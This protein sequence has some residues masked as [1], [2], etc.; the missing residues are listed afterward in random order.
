LARQNALLF[1]VSAG[2]VSDRALAR[3]DLTKLRLAAEIQKNIIPRAIGY[4]TFRP[5][6]KYITGTQD[7]AE[8]QLIPFVFNTSTKAL[9]ELTPSLMRVLVDDVPVT[10]G[11]VS[12]AITNGTFTS[13]VASW[14]D[15]DDVGGT[16]AWVTGGYLGLTGNG[17][18]F[19]VR[20][21]EVTVVAGDQ[22]DEH[23]LRIIIERGPVVFRVGSTEGGDEY[24]NETTLQTGTHSLTFTPT[25]NFWIQFQSSL[26]RQV[27]VDSV[28]VESSGVMTLPTPWGADEI[29]DIHYHQSGDVVFCAQD[30]T[31]Q[32]RIERRSAHSWSVV[33]YLSN[34]G[35]FRVAATSGIK[36]TPNA[37]TGNITLTASKPFFRSGHV[38]ALFRLAHNKQVATHTVTGAD[39]YTD[40]IR[41][42]GADPDNRFNIVITGLTGTGSTV[43]YQRSIDVKDD[44]IDNLPAETANASTDVAS[45]RYDNQVFYVRAGVKSG[46]YST[47]TPAIT[48]TYNGGTKNGIVRITAVASSTS[49]SAEVISDL[50][51][52]SATEVWDEGS[53]SDVRGW[54][55][56]VTLHDGRLWW[57][58]KDFVYGSVSDE[59]SN[60]DDTTVG[61]SG[62]I[63]RSLALGPIEGVI[64]LLSMQRLLGGTAS[65]VVSMRASSLDEPMTPTNFGVREISNRGT[66]HLQAVKVDT[67]GIYVQ[68]NTTRVREI[69]FGIENNDYT[70]DDLTKFKP[71]MCDAGIVSIAVQN[72]PDT[73]IWCV[74]DDGSVAMCCYDRTEEMVSWIDIDFGD[75]L[76]VAVTV[77]PGTEEDDVYLAI[78]RTINGSD[79]CY[80]EKMALESECVGGSLNKNMDSHYVYSGASTSTI[81]GLDHLEGE[82]VVV[83]GNS[84]A[85]HDQ[86]DMK[87]VTSGSITIGES[88][89][90]AVVGLPYDGRFKP[91]KLAYGAQ[92]GTAIGQKK[93]ISHLLILLADTVHKGITYGRH[94]DDD[95]DAPANYVMNSLPRVYKGAVISEDKL[96]DTFEAEPYSFDGTWDTDARF[97]V[98]AM[99]PYPAHIL[100]FVAVMDTNEK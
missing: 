34:A 29:G 90:S 11:S 69:V 58:G 88:V 44:W 78:N 92:L 27:L 62:P 63:V 77:L 35:P 52:T 22:G 14:T 59:F 97:C 50:G 75:G 39:Q 51:D 54:P 2:E 20:K 46:H 71:E 82:S 28:A 67:T 64:W 87:T 96:Y 81:T 72:Q 100:G 24:I 57:G 1:A 49:A 83:W 17:F 84:K 89:T 16:S 93:K 26:K 40:P 7:N 42:S 23:A 53:W 56:T 73:R 4:G 95:S 13:D 38:G 94:F 8:P 65:Q 48:L 9:I 74:L 91:A 10:R 6:T 99:S 37:R 25:G 45:T 70:T 47:G 15:A 21:Q 30:L 43:T 55:E 76:A 19:A 85:L 80:I 12:T 18:V 61:D 5:G 79:V 86:T 41:V 98:K 32:R 60:Y 68:R 66:S 36:L 33:E 31:R 3:I